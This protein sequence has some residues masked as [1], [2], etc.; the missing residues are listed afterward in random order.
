MIEAINNSLKEILPPVG[1]TPLMQIKTK[2]HMANIYAKLEW[3]N[4]TGSIKDRAAIAMVSDLISKVPKGEWG[5]LHI[6]EY[7]GGN[8]SLAIAM[9]CNRLRIKTTLVLSSGAGKSLVDRLTN[10]GADI[11]FVD[12]NK[13]F[14]AVIEKAIELSKE[15]PKWSF[16]YQHQNRSNI[17][18]HRKGTGQE[19]LYQMKGKRIDAWVASVGTGGTLIGVYQ[20]LVEKNSGIELHM[21]MPAEMPYGVDDPPNGQKR[22]AGSGGFGCGR[23]QQFIQEN[24]QYIQKQW[25][26]SY[27]ETLQ[28]MHRFYEETGIKIGTSAAANLLAS[29][30]LAKLLGPDAN[31]V[32]VFPDAG[33]LEEWKDVENIVQGGLNDF[34][35]SN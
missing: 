33:S 25:T 32:T 27:Q 12:K 14:Y 23:K 5:K 35:H 17:E 29:K 19:I 2:D 24:E 30:E 8:L 4:P 9:I 18:A 1:N 15:N 28:E 6:L 10:L 34:K 16:L 22:F 31:I 26:Y 7:S 20:A 13:G 3:Y 11:C 21:V